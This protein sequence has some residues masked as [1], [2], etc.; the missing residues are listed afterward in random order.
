[1][2]WKSTSLR[3]ICVVSG[4]RADYG[5]LSPL[6]RRIGS[7]KLFKLHL[8]VTGSHLSK[9]QGNTFKQIESDGFRRFESIECFPKDDGATATVKAMARGLDAFGEYFGRTKTDLLLLLGDRFEIMVAAQAALIHRIPVAHIHGGEIT[10]G[11]FD[12]SIRHCLTKIAFLHFA[13]NATHRRRIIQMGEPPHSVHSVGAL[14]LD[15]L[16]AT[17]KF[18]REEWLSKMDL[19]K[20]SRYFMV[21]LHP[22]TLGQAEPKS[23]VRSLLAAIDRFPN[24]GVIFT[25]ANID[26]GGRYINKAIEAYC[27]KNSRR[28]VLFSSLGPL[29][30]P[31]SLRHVDVV[32]GNSSSGIIE[33]P[34]LG[35]PT[36]NIGDRQKG[37]LSAPSVIHTA[38][39]EHSIYKAILSALNRKQRKR[40]KTSDRLY[41][42]GKTADRILKILKATPFQGREKKVFFDVPFKGSI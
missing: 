1:M 8:V 18:S 2:A 12:D 35:T 24:A 10:E 13:S 36:V 33:A 29:L 31:N 22:A 39:S 23:E 19:P 16:R 34:F 21:T 27:R 14:G 15:L 7:E 32:I 38:P 5:L 4:G 20:M 9:D 6:L 28:A 37:R 40:N 26:P 11:A 17:P 41:G 25:K 42:D 3:N 30:Y